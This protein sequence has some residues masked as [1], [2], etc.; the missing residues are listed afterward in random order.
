[1]NFKKNNGITLIV[2]IVTIIILLI[3]SGVTI[4]AITGGD[5]TINKAG[6]AK[7]STEVKAEMEEIQKKIDTSASRAIRYGNFSGSADAKTIQGELKDLVTDTS[8]ITGSGPWEIIGSKTGSKYVITKSYE[9][10]FIPTYEQLVTDSTILKGNGPWKVTSK[11]RNTDYLVTEDHQ[12]TLF[13]T[14]EQKEYI[15]STGTQYIDTGVV[16][17]NTVDFE[18][19]F[20]TDVNAMS[21]SSSGRET[22]FGSINDDS[23]RVIEFNFGGVKGQ[24]YIWSWKNYQYLH[25]GLNSPFST[26]TYNPINGLTIS[27]INNVWKAN[28]NIIKTDTSAG[29]WQDNNNSLVVFGVSRIRN[30]VKT[31]YP[32][33]ENMYLYS[34]KIWDN[35]ELVRDFIPVVE[36]GYKNEACLFDLVNEKFYYNSGTGTFETN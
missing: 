12:V 24:T 34:L 31:I 26:S 15:K 16:P 25:G 14:Y 30:Q 5:G 2:L 35:G 4:S 7:L 13:P 11:E 21:V 32:F 33:Y 29:D 1:M 3:L 19:T 36:S 23:Y 28:N 17:A 10:V 6:E 27:C 8:M 20:K 22:F 18:M 9:L